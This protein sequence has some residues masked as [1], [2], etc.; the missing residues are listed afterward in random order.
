MRYQVITIGSGLVDVFIHTHKFQLVDTQQGALLCQLHGS[1]TEV[2]NFN[3]FTGG[4]GGNTA[5][6]FARLGFKTAAICET[7]RDN[8]SYLVT[9]DLQDNGVSTELVISE[10][11]EQTG[12]SVILICENGER[13]ILVH[14]GAAAMLD[15]FDISAYW[16]SQSE[17]VHL[18][19]IGGKEKTLEKIFLA[20][21]RADSTSLSWNPGK[22]ELLLLAE[23]RLIIK[24]IPCQTFLVNQEEW[25]MIADVQS[26]IMQCF[27]TVV[28]TAGKKGG[29]VYHHG[30][31]V[32]HFP[33]LSQEAVDTTGAGDSFATGFVAGLL[34]GKSPQEAAQ[35]GAR[36]SASVVSYYGAKAGLLSKDKILRN[37]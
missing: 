18:S 17:H 31:H 14:R 19:S 8:F 7:G 30:E 32:C 2:D 35:L 4:G 26:E 27:A 12:G 16:L 25:Q 29:E 37:S 15:P 28:V 10:K 11:S 1:K 24:D 21:R 34:W 36:N 22:G 23:R 3:V 13:S 20:V 6:G 9:K 33:A 5:V